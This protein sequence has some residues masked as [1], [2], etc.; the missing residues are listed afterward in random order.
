MG[1]HHR[2]AVPEQSD[3]RKGQRH[4]HHGAM[5]E[6]GRPVVAV[7]QHGEVEKVEYEHQLGNPE[8]RS[9]P[10]QDEAGLQDVVDDEMTSHVGRRLD[11]LG[12]S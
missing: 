2:R 12:I 9:H 6:Q 4:R 10:Q 1:I 5:D 11:P 8:A 7:I 3:I